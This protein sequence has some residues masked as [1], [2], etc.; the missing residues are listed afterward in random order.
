MVLGLGLVAAAALPR[1]EAWGLVQPAAPSRAPRSALLC[2]ARPRASR[3]DP[4]RPSS[5]DPA[6]SFGRPN[7]A[8]RLLWCE[9]LSKS[10]NGVRF[11]FENIA[12][13]IG[14][15]ARLG[16]VGVNGV[17]KSTLLKCLAGVERADGGTVGV[18]G[19]PSIVYVEQEPLAGGT[20]ARGTVAGAL[21]A[22]MASAGATSPKARRVS[23]SLAAL[24]RYWEATAAEEESGAG[25]IS[26]ES[27]SAMEEHGG[28]ALETRL[29]AAASRLG[30]GGPTFR[31]RPVASLSGGER[32]RVA[33]AAA[34]AQV[35]KL[36]AESAKTNVGTVSHTELAW[37]EGWGGGRS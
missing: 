12:L 4:A 19:R 15:G 17:G 11:Q 13:S 8:P 5:P 14:A 16:L 10:Y 30:V 3:T 1:A 2:H 9:G 37:K 36:P 24:R 18:E 32:K 31:T 26:E 25:G 6:E 27:L 7:A 34:L 20:V 21:T 23:G 29:E 35:Q 33:L 28:W 22:Q